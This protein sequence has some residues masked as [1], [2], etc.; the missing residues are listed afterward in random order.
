MSIKAVPTLAG[1]YLSPAKGEPM[2]SV[3]SVLAIASEGLEGDRYQK[4]QGAW[5]KIRAETAVRDVS[6]ISMEGFERVRAI[7]GAEFGPELTRRNL[8]LRGISPEDLSDLLNKEFQIGSVKMRG[9]EPCDP[10]GRPSKLSGIPGYEKVGLLGGL[11][12]RILNTARMQV[13]DVVG[14]L[15]IEPRTKRL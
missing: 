11:R 2:Q 5:T 7:M 1:I 15:G 9:A 6:I 12:A 3:E 10:C 13:G 14:P 4:K 8:V